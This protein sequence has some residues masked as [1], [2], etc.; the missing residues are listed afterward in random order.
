MNVLHCDDY[1]CDICVH[2]QVCQFKSD[3]L[4]QFNLNKYLTSINNKAGDYFKLDSP[5]ELIVRCK[6]FIKGDKK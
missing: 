3:S 4:Y 2:S 1:D 5:F 6:H